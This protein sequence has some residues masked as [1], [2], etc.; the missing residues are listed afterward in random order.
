[1]VAVEGF[2]KTVELLIKSRELLRQEKLFPLA[3]SVRADLEQQLGIILE[4]GPEGTTW[5]SK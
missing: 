2:R 3:D 4:D 1:M 5:R